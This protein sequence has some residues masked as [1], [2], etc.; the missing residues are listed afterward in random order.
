MTKLYVRML[1]LAQAGNL[2]F[3]GKIPETDLS[4]F[5]LE[6]DDDES[7]PLPDAPKDGNVQNKPRNFLPYAPAWAK[8]PDFDRASHRMFPCLF[9]FSPPSMRTLCR[10]VR[11]DG[12]THISYQQCSHKHLL[13]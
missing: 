1:A 12:V 10:C 8:H 5:S 3:P 9:S 7:V 13:G 4:P 2:L 11:I 6:A